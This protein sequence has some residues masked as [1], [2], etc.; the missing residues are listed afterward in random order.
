MV[1]PDGSPVRGP[2]ALCEL[3]GYVYDAWLRSAEV[4]DALGKPDRA[5]KLR[6]KAA[7]LFDKFNDSFWDEESGFYAYML[8]GE[9]RKVLT[10][11]SNPGHL[12]WSGSCHPI[13]PPRWSPG[14]SRRT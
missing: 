8:D 10:V 5:A 11:A 12:L 3:Q 6:Q 9:K 2:K 13:A 7:A 1:Y 4:F 14:C